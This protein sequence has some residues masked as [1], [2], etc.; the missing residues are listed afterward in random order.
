MVL[1]ITI[2]TILAACKKKDDNLDRNDNT[3]PQLSEELTTKLDRLIDSTMQANNLPGVVVGI[4]IPNE[5][6]YFKSYGKAN[7]EAGTDRQFEAPFRIASITKTF[8]ATVIL[9]LVDDGLLSTSDPLSKFLPNFPNADNIS[10]RNLLRMR[11]GI[12]DF[13]DSAM[14]SEWYNNV[15]EY[16]DIDTLINIMATHGNEFNQA[17]QQTV[18]CNGNYT[19]LAKVAEIVSGKSFAALVYEKVFK[20]LNMTSTYYPDKNDFLLKG[21]NRGYSWEAAINGFVDKTELNTSCANAA[22]AIIS[23]MHDLE[24]YARALY[25]GTLLSDSTQQK[26]LET[27]IFEGSSSTLQ[28]GEGILKLGEFYGHTGTIF[29]FSTELF[30]LPAK[31]AVIIINVNRLDLDDHSKSGA[32]FML[33]SKLIFPENVSW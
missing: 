26:R 23:N 18:Y 22:G 6:N 10:I 9:S 32:L 13:A 14:L 5:G 4:W 3:G 1:I 15:N 33:I 28:Y 31:D 17:G 7:L 25:K 19:L 21:N 11:S 29:G 27:E 30:Y 12:V 24:I 16:Y 8:T 20:P 2:S